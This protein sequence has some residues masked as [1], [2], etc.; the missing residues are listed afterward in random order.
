ML[1]QWSCYITSILL[2]GA[3]WACFLQ[4]QLLLLNIHIIN[5]VMITLNK[6]FGGKNGL[7]AVAVNFSLRLV[8]RVKTIK[9]YP[10][11]S[12]VM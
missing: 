5:I 7:T 4:F 9:Y 2:N 10:M 12:F 6:Q 11:V 8:C 3:L 1:C